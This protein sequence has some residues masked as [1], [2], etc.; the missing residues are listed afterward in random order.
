MGDCFF[1]MDW[2]SIK[3]GFVNEIILMTKL[4]YVWL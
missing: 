4:N 2:L 1:G 3:E